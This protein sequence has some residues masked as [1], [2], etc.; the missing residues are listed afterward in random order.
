MSNLL[1]RLARRHLT[2]IILSALILAGFQFLMCA[3]VANTNVNGA[4]E[5]LMSFAPPMVQNVFGPTL[6]SGA[7]DAGLVAFGWN[8]PVTHAIGLAVAITVATRA[9]AGEIEHGAIELVL[10]QPI[11]RGTYLLAHV[12]FAL[13]SLT[14]IATIGVAATAVGQNVFALESFSATRLLTL[15]L[16]FVLLQLAVFAVTLAFSSFGREAGRVALAG[17]L[18]ALLSYLLQAV[19]ALWPRISGLGSYSMHH[20]YDPRLILVTGKFDSLGLLV[21]TAVLVGAAGAAFWRF[22]RRDLP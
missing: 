17:M 18:V 16:N 8:H 5:Q 12:V 3:I 11:S 13:L 4:L 19:A 6:M 22:S 1:G 15:L 20:Y 10:A 14:V 2:M 7:T 21:L 9:V